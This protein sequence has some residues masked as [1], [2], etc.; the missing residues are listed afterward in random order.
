MDDLYELQSPQ[1][2]EVRSEPIIRLPLPVNTALY[3]NTQKSR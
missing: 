1:N 3:R 2:D